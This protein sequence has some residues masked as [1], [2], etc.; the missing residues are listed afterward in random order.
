M[1][2]VVVISGKGGTGKTTLTA[3]FAFLAENN[4]LVDCDVDAADLHILTAPDIKSAEDFSGGVIARIDPEKC[5][6]CGLCRENCRFDAISEEFVVD[7]ISCE[8]CAVCYHTCPEDAVVLETALN[9]RWFVSET[10]FGPMVHA[11][12]RPGEENSGKLVALI[13]NHAKKLAEEQGRDLII[14]D[15]APGVG[16][17]VISSVTGADHVLVVTEPTLSGFHDMKRVAELVRGFN[18]PVSVVI[19]KADVY[20]EVSRQIEEFCSREGIPMLG[21]IPYDPA[22]VKSMIRRQCV[23]ENGAGPVAESVEKIWAGVLK[24]LAS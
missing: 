6:Q 20:E 3:A 17:P 11:A 21:R 23:M 24:N 8:G 14:S 18:I 15:G 2:E 22:V 19:N 1:K 12:L 7:G 5:T 10:R 9:G 13:R 4:V 16:C